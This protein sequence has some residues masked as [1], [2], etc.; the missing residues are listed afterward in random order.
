MGIT[1][2]ASLEEEE[3]PPPSPRGRWT[4]GPPPPCPR[5]AEGPNHFFLAL[6]GLGPVL[7]PLRSWGGW[8][9][10]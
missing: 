6:I 7:I 8:G 4:A 3:I 2:A 1:L 9:T 5:N 10:G